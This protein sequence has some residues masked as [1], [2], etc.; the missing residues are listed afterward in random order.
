MLEKK[1][2][3][4]PAMT[5]GQ[6]LMRLAVIGV[7]VL[8]IGAAFGYTGGWLAP[9]RLTA[10]RIANTFEPG[11][12]SHPGFRRNH[13]KGVCVTGHF[14]SSGQAQALSSAPLFSPGTTTP[15]VGRLALPGPNPYAPDSSVPIRSFALRFTMPDG[16]QWR[17]AMNSMPVFPVA[18]PE[19]FYE[20]QLAG[21]P[22]PKTGKP[23]PAR[24]KAFFASHPETA[25]FREWVKTARPSASFA[26][27]AYYSLNAFVFINDA[28]TRQN[29]R[30]RVVPVGE[31]AAADATPE[32][33]QNYLDKDLNQRLSAGPLR[34]KLIVT[35]A[36]PGDP[37]NDATRPWPAS[38]RQV[39]AGTIVIDK[40]QPQD[41]GPCRDI[42]FDPTVLPQGM[43]ISDDPL[44]P[45]RSSVYAV[46]VDRRTH[47]G[48]SRPMPSSSSAASEHSR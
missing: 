19:S 33:D 41:N 22:D 38:R 14:E 32:H 39:E 9:Q 29:V 30:W 25:N 1:G 16:Q 12:K 36:D 42:N 7:A 20:Q 28:G 6:K 46:S 23:D 26:T 47:E 5:T 40:S 4:P 13:A 48:L 31:P 27:E 10:D 17:A 15:L 11:G 18:T 2:S 43:A 3:R 8:G 44:L 35:V 34:W 21:A 37:S 45:A 24:I